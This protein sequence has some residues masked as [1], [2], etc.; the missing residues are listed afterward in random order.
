M[1]LQWRERR[2]E[3]MRRQRE[4]RTEEAVSFSQRRRKSREEKEDFSQF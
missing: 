2:W 4:W 1:I 3:W